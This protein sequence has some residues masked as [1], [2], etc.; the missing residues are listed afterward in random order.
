M[1]QYFANQKMRHYLANQECSDVCNSIMR[2]Y[3]ANEESAD[4]QKNL[5][6]KAGGL[7]TAVSDVLTSRN[8]NTALKQYFLLKCIQFACNLK[9][10]KRFA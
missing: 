8:K 3:L 7:Y 6:D 5:N 9:I 1:N 4:I 2:Q 10:Y